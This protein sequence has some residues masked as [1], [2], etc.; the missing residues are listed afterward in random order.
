MAVNE[1]DV[2]RLLK[3]VDHMRETVFGNGKVGLDELVRSNS[4]A[5]ATIETV[6]SKL[7]NSIESGTAKTNAQLTN[8]QASLNSLAQER[9][10]D[11]KRR[12]GAVETLKW[13]KWGLGTLGTLLVV[14]SVV[15]GMRSHDT[16]QT[17]KEIGTSLNQLR[18]LVDIPPLNR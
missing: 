2:L 8:L 14:L 9:R 13:F 12:E 11:N 3:E 4:K 6:M 10:D 17:L 15:M 7:N 5:I 16:E 18:N 1:S